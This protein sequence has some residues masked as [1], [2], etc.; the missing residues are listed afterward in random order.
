MR[1]WIERSWLDRLRAAG[2]WRYEL[3][4]EAF[5]SLSDAGM[6]VARRAV[7]PIARTRLED[8]PAALAAAGVEPEVVDSLLPLKPLWQTSLHTSGIRLRNAVG[9]GASG[10][11]L[12][13]ASGAT[14]G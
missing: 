7:A 11:I 8:L 13:P 3:P 9:W 5:E 4:A 6:H 2:L 10:D 1:A 12:P 14:P